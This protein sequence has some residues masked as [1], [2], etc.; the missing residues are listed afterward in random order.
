[1][2]KRWMRMKT[3]MERPCNYDCHNEV[4]RADRMPPARRC[5]ASVHGSA[6]VYF[7]RSQA[8]CSSLSLRSYIC[9]RA[10]VCW[11]SLPSNRPY[12]LTFLPLGST[13]T[14]RHLEKEQVVG[15]PSVSCP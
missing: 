1:M 3:S 9:F 10:P 6:P 14:T 4:C 13:C 12:G 15:F 11:K 7:P 5:P 2:E 8:R